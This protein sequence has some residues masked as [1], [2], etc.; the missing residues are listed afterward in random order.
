M[1]DIYKKRAREPCQENFQKVLH[2]ENNI[3]FYYNC[4]SL[5]LYHY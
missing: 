1:K 3:H 4:K 5:I 2:K